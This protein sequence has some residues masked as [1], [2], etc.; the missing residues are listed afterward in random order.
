MARTQQQI[1]QLNALL[2][3]Y[4]DA[5]KA[6]DYE[7]DMN[8]KGHANQQRGATNGVFIFPYSGT[9]TDEGSFYNWLAASNAAAASSA[10]ATAQALADYNNYVGFLD[11]QDKAEL[12]A[13]QQKFAADNPDVYQALQTT[14]INAASNTAIAK[15]AQDTQA[16]VSSQATTQ[17]LIFGAVALTIIVL[18]VIIFRKQLAP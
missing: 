2:K 11:N 10:N 8:Q 1:D 12:V 5:K 16:A 7:V 13:A 15:S 18:G 9:Q 17:Y 4:S 6:S 14:A 3:A